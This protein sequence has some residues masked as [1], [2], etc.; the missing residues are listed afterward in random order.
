M[1][2][3][4]TQWI[5]GAAPGIS[6]ARLN[7]METGI[8]EAHT[9]KAD[10]NSPTFTGTPLAPTPTIGT[11]TTQLAT[12]AFVNT[13][14]NDISEYPT[15]TVVSR[16]IRI[17]KNNASKT[18]RFY[19]SANII[20]G[21]AITVS[22]DGGTTSKT[23]KNIEG[24]NVID[25]EKGYYEVIADAS[26]FTLRP[27][28]IIKEFY[29][30]GVDGVL[31][32][33]GNITL[34]S[35]LNGGAVVRQHSSVTI[36]AGH[37]LT[38]SNPNSGLVIFSQSNITV[39]GT[40]S[41]AQKGS[42]LPS[43]AIADIAS[44]S[45]GVGDLAYLLPILNTLNGG[46]GGNGGGSGGSGHG[47]GGAGRRLLGGFGGGGK[48]GDVNA[49]NGGNGGSITSAEIGAF[50]LTDTAATLIHKGVNSF[51]L[52]AAVHGKN[53][54]NGSGGNGGLRCTVNRDVTCTANAGRGGLCLGGG[55][56]GG[57]GALADNTGQDINVTY[58]AGHGNNGQYAGGFIL[59]VAKGNITIGGTV[60][61]SGGAGGSGGAN[62]NPNP[63]SSGHG[64]GGAG[65][66]VVAIFHKGT[67]TNTGT[68]NVNGGAGG[69]AGTGVTSNPLA[70][71][72]SSGTIRIQQV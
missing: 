16:Q 20:V 22:L 3:S 36:N 13:G 5:D 24:A 57:G 53:G 42:S 55:G 62:Q 32:T 1:A 58:N 26:F 61:A 33:T 48:A 40:I 29:G 12:T 18:T 68:I 52:F 31:N 34:T 72:G 45:A 63:G 10:K 66:G 7:K 2:Y 15:A 19:L 25:L 51:S 49:G 14:I 54:V 6:A 70:T 43:T 17:P 69:V 71:A 11:N 60:V 65:G 27:N 64:G 38:V 41:M 59:L 4:K 8:D 56:G 35:T 44:I 67:Y 47:I 50:Q 39:N 46:T 30:S 28:G 23:L 37:T 21:T 9:Q